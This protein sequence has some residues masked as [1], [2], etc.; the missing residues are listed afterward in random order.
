[1]AW[2]PGGLM[3]VVE[4]VG[5]KRELIIQPMVAIVTVVWCLLWCIDVD[6]RV[7]CYSVVFLL[8]VTS[9]YSQ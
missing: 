1:V 5:L 9:K 3:N 2:W 7:V 8:Q 6:M 4:A